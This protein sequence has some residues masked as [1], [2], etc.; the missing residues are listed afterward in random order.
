ME[1]GGNSDGWVAFGLSNDDK[2][3][4]IDNFQP[5][6]WNS[7][8]IICSRRHDIASVHLVPLQIVAF[9]FGCSDIDSVCGLLC[10]GVTV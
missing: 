4:C 3:V 2:M 6:S 10:Q 8:Q 9:V 7:F 1:L 5:L